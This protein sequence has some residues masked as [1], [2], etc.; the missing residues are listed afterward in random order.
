M[1]Q[2]IGLRS[3]PLRLRTHPVADPGFRRWDASHEYGTKNYMKIKEI[4]LR[5]AARAT[6]TPLIRQYP[7]LEILDPPLEY[8]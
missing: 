6:G 7:L 2:I 8:I 1:C 3:N 5:E 4:G